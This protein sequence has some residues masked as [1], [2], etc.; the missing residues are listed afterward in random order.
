ME[1]F[2]RA[3]RRAQVERLKHKRQFYYNY[4]KRAEHTN[5]VFMSARQLGQVVQYPAACS[6]TMCG[7]ARR[8]FG[9][10]T[11]QEQRMFQRLLQ[12]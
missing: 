7:N 5:Q 2:N 12:E 4:G 8:H 1:K 9:Q 6:C 10:L 11:M 3:E